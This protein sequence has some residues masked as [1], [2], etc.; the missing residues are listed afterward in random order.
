MA[1]ELVAPC[2]YAQGTAADYER[3]GGLKA[4]YEAAMVD[5]AGAATWIGA[6]RNSNVIYLKPS[7]ARIRA[8][9]MP[10]SVAAW[11]ALGITF[12]VASG[13]ARCRS[14]AFMNGQTIS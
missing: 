10:G 1:S 11:P 4:K 3:A 14:H 2:T 7:V 9:A 6:S 5:V 13:Q 8:S 12:N